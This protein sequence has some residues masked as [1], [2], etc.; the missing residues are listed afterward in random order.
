MQNYLSITD[1]SNPQVFEQAFNTHYSSLCAFAFHY[2]ED[3]E[4]AEEIVQDV[5]AKV[6]EGAS[7]L[8]IRTNVK[9]YLLGAVRH[10]SLNFLKHEKVKLKHQEHEMQK[11]I[12]YEAD[13][14]EIDELQQKIDEALD[15]LPDRCREIFEMSRFR[16]MKYEEI[17]NELNIS[18]KTVETQI[19][20]A[21]KVM[22]KEL[23]HYLPSFLLF[24]IS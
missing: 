23:G 19:S 11:S 22:R 2:T 13:F 14:M 16:E 12:A 7:D 10:A 3:H 15:A 4:V 21:L 17:A 6:W 5:F 8:K 1:L 24:L 9:S 20:R 18:V